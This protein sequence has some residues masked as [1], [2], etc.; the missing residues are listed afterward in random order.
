M[1]AVVRSISDR[2]RFL[3][4]AELQYVLGL[5]GFLLGLVVALPRLPVWLY[6]TLAV[7]TA[8]ISLAV[9]LRE[10]TVLGRRWSR[11]VMA[12][13]SL[14]LQFDGDPSVPGLP[15]LIRSREGTIA[16]DPALD[17]RLP[18]TPVRAEMAPD[19]FD[20]PERLAGISRYVMA[21]S[22]QGQW[23]FNGQN[24]RLATNIDATWLDR[25]RPAVVQA[26]D[27]F[28]LLC[29]NELTKWD[30]TS[31]DGPFGFREE[32]LFD[33]GGN[34]RPL[35]S[36][37]L[38][39]SIGTSTLAVTTDDHLVVTLQSTRSQA[40]SG[41]LAPSG[42]GALEP[43]DLT[44]GSTLQEFVGEGA[45]REL[46]EETTIPRAAVAATAVIGY[47]R[48]LDRGAKPEFFSVSALTVSSRDFSR[49]GMIHGL[50]KEE[51]LWTQTID[52]APLD[53]EAPSRPGSSE[54]VA[55]SRLDGSTGR[56][57]CWRETGLADL[58]TLPG[59]PSVPLDA[60]LDA[61]VRALRAEPGLLTR[62]R[63]GAA[64]EGTRA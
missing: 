9:V 43:R 25:E 52:F 17:R 39:N 44:P 61:L 50:L 3:L 4:Q 40:S 26:S 64:R 22:G 30:I 24:V 23:P 2:L 20:L 62:L 59:E 63:G 14:P 21:R 51:R 56:A 46:S 35:E 19:V 60:A 49:K 12:P 57:P 58:S 32:F 11:W 29:S 55:S 8:G 54:G 28:S 31:P 13:R 27:F 34:F 15:V 38:N 47:G 33:E 53:L 5:L 6:A 41:R 37:H 36:S 45:E 1:R 42:S 16:I 18:E 10:T 48:W 7:A